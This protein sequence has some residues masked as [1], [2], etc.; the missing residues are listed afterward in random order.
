MQK[1]FATLG[2]EAGTLIHSETAA[3]EVLSLPMH[4]YLNDGDIKTI[5]DLLIRSL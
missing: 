4:P 1:A 3:K 5:C 2:A